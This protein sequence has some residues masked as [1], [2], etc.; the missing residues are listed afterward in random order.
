M[1]MDFKLPGKNDLVTLPRLMG[2]NNGFP[3]I[4]NIADVFLP[5]HCVN[6]PECSRPEYCQNVSFYRAGHTG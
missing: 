6:T 1:M 4:A 5:W 3:K 2:G